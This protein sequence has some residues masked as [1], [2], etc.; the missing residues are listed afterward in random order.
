MNVANIEKKI[1]LRNEIKPILSKVSVDLGKEL[2]KSP[3][4]ISNWIY[5]RPHMF[6]KK[7]IQQAV[8]KVTGLTKEQIF[9]TNESEANNSGAVN[10]LP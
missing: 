3:F 9:E 10:T 4:T 7:Y 6:Q 1:N 8:K 2:E 5:N